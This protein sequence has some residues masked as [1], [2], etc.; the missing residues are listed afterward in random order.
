MSEAIHAHSVYMQFEWHWPLIW[1]CLRLFACGNGQTGSASEKTIGMHVHTIDTFARNAL[2]EA[3]PTPSSLAGV[4][5]RNFQVCACSHAHTHACPCMLTH[6]H[7]YVLTYTVT[8]C[9]KEFHKCQHS[10]RGQDT[11]QFGMLLIL[12]LLT[13]CFAP[14]MVLHPLCIRTLSWKLCT[15]VRLHWYCNKTVHANTEGVLPA[16]QCVFCLEKL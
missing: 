14:G 13:T 16:V 10:G 8:G 3:A 7:T 12:L 1:H 15:H 2:E 11:R 4:E 6:I 5:E 9:V